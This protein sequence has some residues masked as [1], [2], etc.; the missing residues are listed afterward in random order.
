M[1]RTTWPKYVSLLLLSLLFNVPIWA[2]EEGEKLLPFEADIRTG[3]LDNGLKY[4]IKKNSKPED[5]VELRLVVNAGS[6]LEDEDQQGLAHFTEHMAFNGSAHFDKNELVSYLQSVGVKFGAHLNAYTSFDETVYILPIP[7]DDEEVLEQGLTILEDWAGGLSFDKDE[8]DKERG[9]VIEEWRL[10]QG[11]QTR[12]LQEYLP[13]IFKD[14]KYA[15]RL[16]IGKKEILESFEREA[17]VRFYEDWYRPDLMAVVAVGDIDV[18]QMEERIKT[19]FGGLANPKSERVRTNYDLPEN[20]EPLVAI[21]SD[22]EATNIVFNIMYKSKSEDVTTEAQYRMSQIQS[23]FLG[24]MNQRLSDLLQQANPPYLYAG[25]YI[26]SPVSR[27][28]TAFS[29]YAVAKPGAIEEG[30]S[31][32]LEE[33]RRVELHG[34]NPSEL[35][36]A[37]LNL[38]QAYEQAYLERDKSQ[39]SALADELIRHFLEKEPVPG[40]TFEY[41]YIQENLDGITIDEVNAIIGQWI[42]PENRVVYMTAPELDGLTLPTASEVLS[43]IA[44]YEQ[45]DVEA[46]EEEII[47]TDLLKELPKGGKVVSTSTIDEIDTKV[48]V[49]SNGAK[50][51]LKSTEFQNDQILFSGYR[52]GG[53]SVAPDS[54]FWSASF[55]SNVVSLSGIGDYSYTQLQKAL[56]GV[57]IGVSPYISELSS[58]IQGNASPKDVETMLQL[59]YMYFNQVRKD[60]E[61]FQSLIQR[62]KAILENVLSNPSYYFQDK[63]A[64]IMSQ[65]HFR[66]GGIPRMEDLDQV[67]MNEA[68]AF[69]QSQLSQPGDF[70]YC[71]VGNLDEETLIP[72]IEQYLGGGE[73][74]T[75]SQHWVDRGIRPPLGLVD[76]KVYKGTEEQ[77]T[78]VMS[79][80]TEKKY[81]RADSYYMRSLGEVL[82][83]QLIEIL[84]EEK[85]GVYGVGASGSGSRSP[86]DHYSMQIQFPCGPQNVDTLV[87][88]AIG[89][90]KNI[91]EN[92]VSDENLNKIKEAQRRDLELNWKENSFWLGVILSYDKNGFDLTKITELEDRI[93]DLSAKDIQKVAKKYV[94]TDAYIKVVLYPETL[95]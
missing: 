63:Q 15:E 84:R 71:F 34:F 36:T 45:K 10:G 29:G 95:E 75:D 82:D 64:R 41:N 16:P 50:V 8:I 2:Q 23:L 56:A 39:S 25:T 22:P 57:S 67:D 6:V 24:M 20:D 35:K 18:D 44:S 79:F 26:G 5:R 11:A 30:V 89:V 91:Q 72:L 21:T 37:K 13:V 42:K 55:A 76:E 85:S 12:M 58:G 38:L 73:Q 32:L 59:T 46:N 1:K 54:L 3:E 7:S 87:H 69:F 19:H 9:V 40:I 78:V 86:Y 70:T 88:A 74:S 83:I 66:G 43:W 92:G 93:E 49:L 77:S 31:Q 28:T 60:E 68:I 51:Y 65:N 47:D 27:E 17:I 62:N 61:A 81:K 14:S 90:V 53:I 33:I 48:I 94:D 80:Q 4:F 52:S